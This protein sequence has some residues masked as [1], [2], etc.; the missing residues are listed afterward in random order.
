MVLGQADMKGMIRSL[1]SQSKQADELSLSMS[2]TA[3]SVSS[4][5]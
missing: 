5:V 1:D 4:V 2:P 3:C